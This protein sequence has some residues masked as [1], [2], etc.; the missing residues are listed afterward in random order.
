VD[1]AGEFLELA[2]GHVR[3]GDLG[4]RLGDR[5]DRQLDVALLDVVRLAGDAV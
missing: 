5:G 1:A 4:P 2:L 3:D